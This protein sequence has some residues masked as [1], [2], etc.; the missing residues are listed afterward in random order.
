MKVIT[1]SH[2]YVDDV[3]GK[4][5]D[6]IAFSFQLEAPP[7]AV[8]TARVVVPE[9][10]SRN[11]EVQDFL[12]YWSEKDQT[13]GDL[14]LSAWDIVAWARKGG[15]EVA[16]YLIRARSYALWDVFDA[17]VWETVSGKKGIQPGYKT[18]WLGED[19]YAD[20][21]WR[22]GKRN[23][24]VPRP[25]CAKD[26]PDP[27]PAEI[28][29]LPGNSDRFVAFLVAAEKLCN[30]EEWQRG[31]SR[32]IRLSGAYQPASGPMTTLEWED[33]P[34]RRDEAQPA[35]LFQKGK[36]WLEFTGT[37][38]MG[39]VKVEKNIYH[40]NGKWSYSDYSLCLAPDVQAWRRVRE[41]LIIPTPQI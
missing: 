20:L 40:K 28:F 15:A 22:V 13:L 27:G 37:S 24:P 31:I 25:A 35:L 18:R 36:E 4:E 7:L 26:L 19:E 21:W 2:R 23:L 33:K 3:L 34:G 9:I 41:G 1:T 39:W 32:L 12:R 5:K 30:R 16:D 10:M 8:E 11:D 38:R 6:E 17:R 14:P 29:D